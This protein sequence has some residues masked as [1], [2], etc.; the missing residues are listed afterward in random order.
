PGI[1]GLLD[2]SGAFPLIADQ[3]QASQHLAASGLGNPPLVIWCP[4]P[5][6]SVRCGQANTIA[7]NLFDI[8]LTNVTVSPRTSFFSDIANPAAPFDIAITGWI[9]DFVDPGN[10]ILP[11]LYRNSPSNFSYWDSNSSL[12]ASGNTWTQRMDAASAQVAP[13]RYAAFGQLA[14]ELA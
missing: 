7:S 13:N 9:A 6:T 11:L 8:G 5:S 3:A 14:N 12:D 4:A 2:D 1:P 10:F